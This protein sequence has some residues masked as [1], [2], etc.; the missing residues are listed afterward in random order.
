MIRE[1]YP[2]TLIE[3]ADS[4]DTGTQA[5]SAVGESAAGGRS[6]AGTAVTLR[7]TVTTCEMAAATV[8]RLSIE[9]EGRAA[10]HFRSGQYVRLRVPGTDQWRSYS[11]ASTP[12]D[13]PRLEFLVR[14]IDGGAMAQYLLSRLRPGDAIDLEGPRGAFV[15]RPHRAPHLFVAGGT[16]LAPILFADRRVAPAPGTAPADPA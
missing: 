11:I 16:D 13:L 15:L 7:A 10:F 8:A 4:P 9:L 5:N 1:H 14:L 12:R 6:A 2:S 3:P